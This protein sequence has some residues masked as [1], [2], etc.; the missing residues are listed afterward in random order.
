[1]P[2]H[3]EVVTAERVVFSDDVD[4]VVATGLEGAL[5]ILPKHAPLMAV[6]DV[7][8]LKYRKGNQEDEIAIG[9]GFMEVLNDRV[10]VLADTAERSEEIDIARAEEAQQRAQ[11]LLAERPSAETRAAMD[12]ALRRAQ[13]RLKVARRRRRT[14]QPIP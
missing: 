12:L 1:M 4:M 13:V 9:G 14:G 7:G 3:L 6:L 11:R 2:L 5:G 8:P 10:T